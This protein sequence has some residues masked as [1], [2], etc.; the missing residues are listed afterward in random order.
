MSKPNHDKLW[1]DDMWAVDDD[2]GC[3][4]CYQYYNGKCNASGQ[5]FD[6]GYCEIF[7]HKDVYNHKPEHDEYE[8]YMN[9]WN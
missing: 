6:R 4:C 9:T 5:R 8:E 7:I 1:I 2:V 3:H